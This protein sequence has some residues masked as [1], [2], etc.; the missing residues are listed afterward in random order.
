MLVLSAVGATSAHAG[1]ITDSFAQGQTPPTQTPPPQK[2]PQTPPT[3]EKPATAEK[4]QTPP[5]AKPP[6]STPKPQPA[7]RPTVTIFVTDHSGQP[8]SGVSVRAT[9]PVERTGETDVEGTLVFRNM[10]AG[11][12]RL[13]FE[14]AKFVTFDREV[15]VQA[16]RPLKTTAA[17]DA[18]P[19]PP[20]PPKPEPAATP[21]PPPAPPPPPDVEPSAVAITDFIEKNYIGSAPSK[22][23]SLGCTASATAVLIQLRDPLA[24]H[25]HADSDEFLYVVAGEGTHRVAGKETPLAPATLAIVPR[26]KPHS[27]ARKGRSPLIAVS[28]LSGPPCS[29]LK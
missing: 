21:P 6:V 12:Y 17:L 5:G 22:Y 15:T 29:S 20:P 18:A 4:P 26:G 16:G 11:T 19:P 7:A 25:T 14:H 13:R 9:G 10:T 28:I 24:E 27:L 8:I 1:F 23:S 2:P 3:A